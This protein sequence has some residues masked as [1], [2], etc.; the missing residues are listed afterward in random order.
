MKSVKLTHLAGAVLLSALLLIS[1][2]NEQH[3]NEG[4]TQNNQ[5]QQ[6]TNY[7]E[8][9]G[10]AG[11]QAKDI[12]LVTT[13]T[14]TDSSPGDYYDISPICDG[15]FSVISNDYSLGIINSD[16]TTILPCKYSTNRP[17]VDN[18]IAII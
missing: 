1:C 14:V 2:S 15:F 18:I 10:S 5:N 3:K 17:A 8:N 4:D 9:N 16:L 6:E 12:P 7:G 11:E 13:L